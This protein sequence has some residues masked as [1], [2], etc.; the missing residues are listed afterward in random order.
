MNN[1]FQGEV[2]HACHRHGGDDTDHCAAA[3]QSD[4][5][6]EIG[7]PPDSDIEFEIETQIPAT[8]NDA[9]MPVIRHAAPVDSNRDYPHIPVFR[10]VVT[11]AVVT[12]VQKLSPSFGSEGGSTS[13]LGPF[14]SSPPRNATV[15]FG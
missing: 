7:I 10:P 4:G 6:S 13:S 15:H 1:S 9:K 12:P 5:D 2:E 3:P 8:E 11:N 14:S